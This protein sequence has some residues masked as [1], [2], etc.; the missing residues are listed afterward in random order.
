MFAGFLITVA[1][2]V[3]YDEIAHYVRKENGINK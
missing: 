2:Y 3:I 1:L